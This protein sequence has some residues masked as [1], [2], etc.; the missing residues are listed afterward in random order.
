MR[1]LCTDERLIMWHKS[2][3][4]GVLEGAEA[5]LLKV[6]VAGW[7]EEL[8]KLE[9]WDDNPADQERVDEVRGD[10]LDVAHVARM[11]HGQR[12]HMIATVVH[13]LLER[14]T[15]APAL[16]ADSEAT[17][18]QIYRFLCHDVAVDCD[19][20]DVLHATPDANPVFERLLMSGRNAIAAAAREAG[21]CLSE[22]PECCESETDAEC[23]H[24]PG[25]DAPAEEWHAIV[26]N[27]ADRVL[28]DRDWEMEEDLA[29][30]E[31]DGADIVKRLAG[32][33]EGYFTTPAE[34]PSERQVAQARTYLESIADEIRAEDEAT[35]GV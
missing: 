16:T 8:Q 35:A 10:W 12:L 28:W 31:P 32:I 13:A 17:V 18:Y 33:D 26:E 22:D 9:C 34:E 6:A 2:D 21:L 30:A 5:R 1:K 3:G 27:L 15:T 20:L 29:D 14:S 11:E 19:E 25:E 4:G 7:V 23:P 24:N